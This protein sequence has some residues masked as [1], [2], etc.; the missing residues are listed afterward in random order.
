MTETGRARSLP[1]GIAAGL[2]L[3]AAA[4]ATAPTD[5]GAQALLRAG[6]LVCDGGGGW[7]AIIGS[8]KSFRCT[9]SSD[10]GAVRESYSATVQK[11][12]LD[13]GVTGNTTLTWLVFGPANLVGAH[14]AAGSLDGSYG[15][16]GADASIGVGLGANALVGGGQNSF[17]L[18]P[19]SVQVQTGL[20][21][22]AGVQTLDLTFAG[23]VN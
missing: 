7:G 21:I 23:Q 15:G 14:Y 19:V 17:A 8:T 13:L 12:G 4:I 11:F 18:Q 22:A 10:Q 5:A 20:S 16:I 1:G 3:A 2:A 6:V 9:F